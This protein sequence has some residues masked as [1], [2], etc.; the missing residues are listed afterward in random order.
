MESYKD[1]LNTLLDGY[2]RI[3]GDNMTGFYVHGSVAFGCYNPDKSDIDYIVT[4]RDKIDREE[5]LE[6]L[7][8][9][10]GLRKAAPDKGLEMS[11]VLDKYA[12]NFVYPTPFELH[13]SEYWR[14]QYERDPDSICSDEEKTDIDL[15][16]HFTVIKKTGIVLYGD[17]IEE[18]FGEVKKEYY[19]DS[20]FGDIRAED[21][22][23]IDG[24]T[25]TDD[26]PMYYVLNL[27]R[28]FAYFR[29]GAIISKKQG[30]EYMIGKTPYDDIISDALNCYVYSRKM[31]SDKSRVLDFC[32]YMYDLID[33]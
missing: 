30:G 6:I 32:H 23:I 22:E 4:V 29:D 12:K 10:Y 7:K 8:L 24:E 25:I 17:P 18:K 11:I 9:M 14:E 20:V 31:T 27:C 21:D 26:T 1:V 3:L 28:S 19:I 15:A 13:F 33:K 2:K 5:K 16:A